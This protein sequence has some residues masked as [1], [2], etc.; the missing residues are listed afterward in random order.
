M[1]DTQGPADRAGQKAAER[2]LHEGFLGSCQSQ[3]TSAT[4]EPNTSDESG[5]FL[6]SR[7]ASLFLDIAVAVN[8]L[9]VTVAQ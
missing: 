7:L 1:A 3:K 6:A 5:H 8:R 4:T 2:Q 9:G